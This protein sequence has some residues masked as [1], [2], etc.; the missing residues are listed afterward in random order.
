MQDGQKSGLLKEKRTAPKK[1]KP[2]DKMS[3]AFAVTVIVLAAAIVLYSAYESIR[4][5]IEYNKWSEL[6][7]SLA[8]ET[9]PP[10]EP[11]ATEDNSP[12]PL[13]PLAQELLKENPDTVGWLKI[14]NTN[15]NYPVVQKKSLEDGGNDYYTN[16]SFDGSANRKGAVFSDYRTTIEDRYQSDN[17]V[18]YAHNEAANDM[19]GDL[20]LYKNSGG[21]DWNP[22][23]LEF[24]KANPTFEFS[25]NYTTSTYKIMAVFVTMRTDEYD[26]IPLFDYQN[27]IDFTEDRYNDF[28]DNIEKRNKLSTD[29]DYKYGDRF[30]TLSTCSNEASDARLV[31]I[32]RRVRDGESTKVDT[33]AAEF[34]SPEYEH[35]W[36]EI[37]K[38]AG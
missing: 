19:F 32:G 16:H 21:D 1:K 6:Q 26:D 8:T 24:Y 2:M 29:V 4:S 30:V 14:N 5:K 31:I 17:I 36:T 13:T 18:I 9:P 37:Y 7:S 33:S 35:D 3:I 10:T 20:D 11:V 34:V 25:T 28:I 15:V 23:A 38:N 12:L 22:K 27:Y